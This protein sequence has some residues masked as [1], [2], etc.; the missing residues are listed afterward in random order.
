MK[1]TMND[2]NYYFL[3]NPIFKFRQNKEKDLFG[4]SNLFSMAH[5]KILELKLKLD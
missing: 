4:K 3:K 2:P 5:S 1:I